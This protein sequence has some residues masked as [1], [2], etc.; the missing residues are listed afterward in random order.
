MVLYRPIRRGRPSPNARASTALD[1]SLAEIKRQPSLTAFSKILSYTCLFTLPQPLLHHCC[2]LPG[3]L[4]D[5]SKALFLPGDRRFHGP[6]DLYIPAVFEHTGAIILPDPF[7]QRDLLH[8]I[9][10]ADGD[11]LLSAIGIK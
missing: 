5:L 1:P 10:G 11:P 7:S 4:Y 8:H 2:S 9:G 6:H 3:I